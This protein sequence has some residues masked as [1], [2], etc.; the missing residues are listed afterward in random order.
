MLNVKKKKKILGVII[1]CNAIILLLFPIN[2]PVPPFV[3]DLLDPIMIAGSI[4]QF[5]LSLGLILSVIAYFKGTP[6]SDSLLF[7]YCWAAMIFFLRN[8]LY[9]WYTYKDFLLIEVYIN[10][11][12]IIFFMIFQQLIKGYNVKNNICSVN[13]G[14]TS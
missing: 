9:L 12:Y 14:S 11:I 3:F 5:F 1:I 10:L 13:L 8:S 4:G 7:I 2:L 6:N